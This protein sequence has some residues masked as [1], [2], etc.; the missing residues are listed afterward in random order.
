MVNSVDSDET[1]HYE[2]SHQDLHYLKKKKMFWS[3]GLKGITIC[4]Y[5][6]S[7]EFYMVNMVSLNFQA[8]S[9]W[10]GVTDENTITNFIVSLEQ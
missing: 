6:V 1:A 7:L 8:E 10:T 4:F 3:A 5:F 9:L 2:P